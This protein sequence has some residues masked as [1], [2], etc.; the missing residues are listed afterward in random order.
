[1]INKAI[2]SCVSLGKSL[3]LSSLGFPIWKTGL[4][5]GIILAFSFAPL[6][7][8]QLTSAVG[9]IAEIF[10]FIISFANTP[11]Q[12]ILVVQYGYSLGVGSG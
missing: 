2:H 11:L 9:F 1:M 3:L 4:L 8:N 10:T 7:C 5:A 12:A 6:T